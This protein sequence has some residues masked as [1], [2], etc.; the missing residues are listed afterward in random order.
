MLDLTGIVDGRLKFEGDHAAE[1]WRATFYVT[2]RN[3]TDLKKFKPGTRLL[4]EGDLEQYVD[5]SPG[6]PDEVYVVRAR[7]TEAK[8]PATTVTGSIKK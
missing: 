6:Q 4:I 3:R 7:L 8:E 1:N 2:P 5:T